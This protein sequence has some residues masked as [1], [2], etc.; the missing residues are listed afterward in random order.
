VLR[1]PEAFAVDFADH[2]SA[3]AVH[4]DSMDDLPDALA[5]LGLS[6]RPTLVLVGGADSLTAD[7]LER[8]HGL[9]SDTVAPLVEELGAQVI[10]GA[11]DAGVMRLIGRAREELRLGFP[12]IGVAAIGNVSVPGDTSRLDG[13]DLEPNHSHFVLVTGEGWGREAPWI[14][15]LASTLAN[16]EASV[17]LVVNGG[18]VSWTDLSESI[19][20]GRPIV[21]VAG[22]GGTAD[23]V[24]S[25]LDGM[26][27][28]SRAEP[29]ES[30]GLLVATD[31]AASN[32]SVRAALERLLGA[33]A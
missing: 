14:A 31:P 6:S 16:G 21:A 9:F 33:G 8:L 1:V 25:H 26:A 30:S 11:T 24:V 19:A 32:T 12:L 5:A 3:K 17:T 23:A 4:V 27:T 15:R 13:V 18:E 20:Q 28:D 7:E 29:L 2:R 22:S 10:D